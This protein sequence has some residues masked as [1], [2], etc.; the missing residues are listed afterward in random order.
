MG[1]IVIFMGASAS[2]KDAIKGRILKENRY[3]LKEIILHTTRP[4]RTGEVNG[5]EYYFVSEEERLAYR[6]SGKIIENRTYDTMH[7]KWSYFTVDEKIDLEN[8]NYLTSNTLE[9]YDCFLRYYGAQNLL[10]LY[11][12]VEDGLRL[13]RAL[14]REQKQQ[15]P[16][17]A[18]LCRRFLADTKDFSLEH[19]RERKIEEENWVNNSGSLED[20]FKQIDK[21]LSLKL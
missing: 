7:G 12:Y 15:N 2:G 10:P 8:N 17:Y 19:I 16:K 1:K 4:M 5:R 6:E 9:G 14:K 21:I 13:E 20:S 18:E 11:F 3:D